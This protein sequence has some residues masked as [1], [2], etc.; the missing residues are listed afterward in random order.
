MDDLREKI[1]RVDGYL[2]VED[3]IRLLGEIAKELL[4][5]VERKNKK[6]E[7]SI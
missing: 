7:N 1:N 4:E 5:R 3:K 6:H 2:P